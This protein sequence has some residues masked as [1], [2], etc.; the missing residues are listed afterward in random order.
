M[1]NFIKKQFLNKKAKYNAIFFPGFPGEYKDRLLT[2]DLKK[3]GFN[4]YSAVYPGSHGGEGIFNPE[5]VDKMI[6]IIANYINEQK[7]PV[8]LITY[9]FSTYFILSKLKKF[10]KLMGVLLFS[11]IMDVHKSIKPNFIQDLVEISKSEGFNIDINSWKNYVN[12]NNRK[13]EENYNNLLKNNTDIPLVFAIGDNDP[14]INLP[15]LNGF[16]NKY[17]TTEG[18]NKIIKINVENG[19]HKLDTLYEEK[20]IYKIIVA[21]VFSY[22]LEDKYPNMNFYLWG[23]ALNYRYAHS[24][25]DIDIILINKT[26]GFKDFLFLNRYGIQFG[27]DFGVQMDLSYNTD[28]EFS[29][30]EI[31]RSNRGPSFVHELKYYYWPLK[32]SRKIV[33]PDYPDEVIKADAMFA[34][35]SNLYKSKKGILFGTNETTSLKYVMSRCKSNTSGD[36]KAKH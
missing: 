23:G 35:S 32:L 36:P 28:L 5:S 18:Y 30:G 2:E 11:P 3:L 25:T 24:T 15:I 12:D 19:V 16:L 29:S 21:L 20:A 34:D 8:L 7:L 33:I 6:E 9:S 22:S 10:N 4:M 27:K 1:N 13:F 31:I 14:V 26:F 17:I